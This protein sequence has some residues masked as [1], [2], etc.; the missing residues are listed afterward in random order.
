M[1]REG[2]ARFASEQYS[3]DDVGNTEKNMYS[4][5]TN[6]SINKNNAKYVQ[7]DVSSF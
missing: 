2:L 1:Y 6:Y 7:N 4:H 3:N 5:L